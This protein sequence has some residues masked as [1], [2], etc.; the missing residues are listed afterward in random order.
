MANTVTKA[1]RAK[2]QATA[3]RVVKLNR[4]LAIANFDQAVSTIME[5]H[6]ISYERAKRHAAKAAR[7]QRHKRR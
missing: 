6:G 1:E 7:T 5:R 2:I 3:N 4:D